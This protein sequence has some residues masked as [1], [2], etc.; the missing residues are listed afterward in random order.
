MDSAPF[1]SDFFQKIKL[2]CLPLSL[3]KNKGVVNG[4]R[5]KKD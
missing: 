2:A 5:E 3:G 1:I 4:C